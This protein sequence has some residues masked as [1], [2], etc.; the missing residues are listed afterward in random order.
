[1]ALFSY[2][3]RDAGGSEVS[4]EMDGISV[5]VIASQLVSNGI[6]PIRITE[7]AEKSS[8]SFSIKDLFKSRRAPDISEMI[9]FSRQMFTLLKAGVAINQAIKG[10]VRSIRNDYFAEVL[11]DIQSQ[12]EGGQDLSRALAKYPR[13]FPPLYISMVQVGENT[14][15][16]DEAFLQIS[17][18]MEY[19]KE[20]RMRI[21]SALRYPSFVF[22]AIA[23]ATTVINL[24]VIPAF[25]KIFASAK[26]ELPLPTKILMTTSDAFVNHWPIML[27][28]LI[29]IIIAVRSWLNTETG[30][31][32]WDRYKLKLPLVGDIIERAVL[33]RFARAFA[34]STKAGVPLT[35]ALTVVARAVDN[36]YVAEQ[37]NTI[38]ADVE[39]GDTLT[40]SAS[41]TG[42]FTPLV[43]QMLSVGEETGAVDDLLQEVAEYYERE[44]DY[45]IKNLSST[46]EPLLITIIGIMV[47]ILALGIFMP[48]WDMSSI[49]MG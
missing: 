3:G 12:L 25:A 34:M 2:Q 37:V 4:G 18:Y 26:T 41:A 30:K 17:R 7:K 27:M 6:T 44:V 33:S 35:R 19:D 8:V 23:V 20:T 47:L 16:L 14:G 9:M 45:D 32:N 10:I 11:T 24:M 1:M 39:K 40:R 28:V 13:V 31:R 29:G 21:K 38:R 43:L 5:D 48:M 46:I 36:H 42:M 15:R 49:S 22:I